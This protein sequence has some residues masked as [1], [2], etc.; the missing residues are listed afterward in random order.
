MLTKEQMFQELNEKTFNPM[1]DVA[2]K[3][4]F[5]KEERKNITLDFLDAFLYERLEHH[6]TDI[7]Y[8]N[9]ELVPLAEDGKLTRLDVRCDLSSGEQ[10]DVEVQV[11]NLKNMRRRTLYYW[12]Q[13]YL[14][15]LA[16]GQ[17]YRDLKPAITINILAF[18]LLPQKAPL[19]MYTIMNPETGD[20]LNKDLS[21]FFVEIPKFAREPKKKISEMTK[22][23]R[24]MAYF[25]NQLDDHEREELAMSDAAISGAMDAARVFL[26]DDDERWNYIN[27]QMA[28]LDYNSGIQDSREEGLKEG[29]REG[30]R[31]GRKE[32]RREGRREGIGIGRVGMLAELVR[33]GVLTLG[34]AAEKAGMPEKEFQKAMENLEMSNEET[35]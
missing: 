6:I 3:F 23:E 27:R 25:A 9:T 1:N 30:L 15:S 17:T 20:E 7:T 5:G 14:F 32:G 19:A 24:W 18:E 31:E 8:K 11:L 33:D 16:R 21:L 26:A 35:P 10:V 4:I 29:R 22:M 34:Q 2:F 28:I 13:M 12:A